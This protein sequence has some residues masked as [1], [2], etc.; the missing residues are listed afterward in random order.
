LRK[1]FH[2]AQSAVGDCRRLKFSKMTPS[3]EPAMGFHDFR[4]KFVHISS[5]I[6]LE[7]IDALIWLSKPDGAAGLAKGCK[8]PL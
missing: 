7:T 1:T 4:E 6:T 8:R 5:P 2:A 3:I